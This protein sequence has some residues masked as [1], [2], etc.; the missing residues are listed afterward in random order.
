MLA[1]MILP[2]FIISPFFFILA[3]PVICLL[4]SFVIVE[5]LNIHHDFDRVFKSIVS[6]N[7]ISSIISISLVIV[8]EQVSF[9]I[10]HEISYSETIYFLN[11][12]K[13]FAV[14]CL[15]FTTLLIECL[16]IQIFFREMKIDRQKILNSVVIANTISHLIS[17]PVFYRYFF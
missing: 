15:Y 1:N 6:T 4:E 16:C 7:A 10:G 14:I 2:L 3:F 12:Y 17:V 5:Y 9:V 8:I 13:F 11:N